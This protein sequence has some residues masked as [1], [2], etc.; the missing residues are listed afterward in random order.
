MLIC[1]YKKVSQEK[2]T[3]NL[4]NMFPVPDQDT[5]DNLTT[6]LFGI[7]NSINNQSFINMQELRDSAIDGA[8]CN[9]S[10]NVGII[11]TGFLNGFLS[12]LS[13]SEIS[14]SV[15][16][17][18]FDH[19]FTA[20]YESIQ[21]PKEGTILDVI[22]AAAVSISQNQNKNIKDALKDASKS[23]KIAL[24][25]T[26]NKMELYKRTS[27]VDAG[28]YGF[29]LIIEG[30][31]E[32]FNK[33]I[34]TTHINQKNIKKPTSFFQII[35]RRYEVVCLLKPHNNTN[36]KNISQKLNDYGDC[37]D[38]IEANQKIKIHIHTDIPDEVVELIPTFGTVIYI[39]TS[40]MAQQVEDKKLSKESIGLVI[41]S[42]SSL[43]IDF[44]AQN[45]IT[46]VPF[47]N[48]W[49]K[50]DQDPTLKDLSIYEKMR[51]LSD[52]GKQYGWPKTSQPSIQSFLNAYKE[53]LQKYNRIICITASPTISGS[54]NCAIQAQSFLPT[55]DQKKIIIPDFRQSGPGQAVLAIK[56]IELIKKGYTQKQIEKYLLPIA[57]SIELFAI[58]EDLNWAIKGGRVTGAKSKIISILQKIH[59]HPV[60]N[61]TSKKV[62]IKKIF[63]KNQPL[64]T[65]TARY[66]NQI[67]NSTESKHLPLKIVIQHGDN[68]KEVE[69]IKKLLTPDRFQIIQDSIISPVVGIHSGPGAIA[70]A[71]L[72]NI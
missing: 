72:K 36:S 35:T 2:E 71:V 63:F 39:Q 59:L 56:A 9:A 18:A 37:L 29:L 48:S 38:I 55:S 53:Q 70:V 24:D 31:L 57:Q 26:Q 65:L 10:G 20:A 34:K 19:G 25:N 32:S 27:T 30:F 64:S 50:V 4:I 41:D 60:V 12:N 14:T 42:A 13:E 69:K 1:A 66:L 58:I 21:N 15:F 7:Y 5:G 51:L 28:G 33:K 68:P 46:I 49:P 16:S 67:A 52:K 6:T 54:Y 45:N 43:D 22:K 47:K 40:D 23:A 3:I 62:E 44:I 17:N 8:I 61:F 11:I